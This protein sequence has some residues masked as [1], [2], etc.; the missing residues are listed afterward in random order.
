MLHSPRDPRVLV[1]RASILRLYLDR[2]SYLGSRAPAYHGMH[3]VRIWDTFS[4]GCCCRGSLGGKHVCEEKWA[5][6]SYTFSRGTRSRWPPAAHDAPRHGCVPRAMVYLPP[7]RCRLTFIHAS[8]PL[9]QTALACTLLGAAYAGICNDKRTDCANWARDGECSGENAVSILPLCQLLF[10]CGPGSL[11]VAS[12]FGTGRC[13]LSCPVEPLSPG[14]RP[15]A[16]C[17]I[18][19]ARRSFASAE[20]HG[21]GLP[22]LL[23]HLHAFLQ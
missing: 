10:C 5:A 21:R 12:G 18:R 4:T 1:G 14:L 9:L 23:R 13:C 19:G 15:R 7:Y 6:H 16:D 8:L 22:A 17:G 2:Q 11:G 20:V 3:V